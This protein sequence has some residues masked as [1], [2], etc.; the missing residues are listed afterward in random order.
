ME[1][2]YWNSVILAV[3]VKH[4]DT[5]CER[6]RRIG[7]RKVLVIWELCKYLEPVAIPNSSKLYLTGN[8]PLPGVAIHGRKNATGILEKP[9]VRERKSHSGPTFRE[10][11]AGRNKAAGKFNVC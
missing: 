9:K 8:G 3:S 10:I 7:T 2:N 1:Y 6:R 4:S 5:A 11:H